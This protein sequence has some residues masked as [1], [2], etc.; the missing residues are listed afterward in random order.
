MLAQ[1]RQPGKQE[2]SDLNFERSLPSTLESSSEI[3]AAVRE[4]VS[5]ANGRISFPKE[6]SDAI[7]F[8][9]HLILQEVVVDSIRHG[10]KFSEDKPIKVR[11]CASEFGNSGAR[12]EIEITNLG[13]GFDPLSVP[14]PRLDE[15]TDK[16]SGRGILL[17]A[18]YASKV[19]YSDKGRVCKLTLEAERDKALK[20]IPRG[21]PLYI[22]IDGKRAQIWPEYVD[23]PFQDGTLP[24]N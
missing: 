4:A 7:D 19:E 6:Q 24:E 1:P 3:I 23:T 14:D 11:F 2:L 5:K 22:Y 21:S 13:D 16:P 18:S 8:H 10:N 12:Y 15:N 20:P 9:V 17:A